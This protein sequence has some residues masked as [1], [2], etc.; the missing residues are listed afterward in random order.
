MQKKIFWR[1]EEEAGMADSQLAEQGTLDLTQTW[2]GSM[3]E[4]DARMG[5]QGGIEKYYLG[6]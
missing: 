2:K 3:Q 5:Y 6:M 4:M 1:V